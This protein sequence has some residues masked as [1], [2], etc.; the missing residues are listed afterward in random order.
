MSGVRTNWS[1]LAFC[2]STAIKAHHCGEIKI[3]H[4]C[5]DRL[6]R[7][8]TGL[9]WELLCTSWAENIPGRWRSCKQWMAWSTLHIAHQLAKKLQVRGEEHSSSRAE[10]LESNVWLFGG[11]K[12]GKKKNKQREFPVFP[13]AIHTWG[14]AEI[15]MYLISSV[16]VN[17]G[18]MTWKNIRKSHQLDATSFH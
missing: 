7:V 5:T 13:Q 1:R 4:P 17:Q 12:K 10:M 18:L 6:L 11:E 2:H 8:R 16:D 15:S 3:Y 14:Q 9:Y